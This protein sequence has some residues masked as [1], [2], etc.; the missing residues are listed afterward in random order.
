MEMQEGY[1]TK[2]KNARS[3]SGQTISNMDNAEA[4]VPESHHRNKVFGVL[5]TIDNAESK[6]LRSFFHKAALGQDNLA[7]SRMAPLCP[8]ET[9]GEGT[10]SHW[11]FIGRGTK[12]R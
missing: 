8:G 2:L 9:T 3:N 4:R 10:A 12:E 6:W 11:I 5:K 1:T 7:R